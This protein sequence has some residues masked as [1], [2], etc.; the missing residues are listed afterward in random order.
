[1]RERTGPVCPLRGGVYAFGLWFDLKGSLYPGP[2]ADWL[3]YYG[4][5]RWWSTQAMRERTGPVCPLRGGVFAFGRWLTYRARVPSPS[6]TAAK[7]T[8][9]EKSAGKEDPVELD[10]S[11]SL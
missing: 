4:L 11:L 5:I 10:T 8:D 6:E 2:R 7:G 9:L 3:S 1:M